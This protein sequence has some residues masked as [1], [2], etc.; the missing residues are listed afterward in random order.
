MLANLTRLLSTVVVATAL[1][2]PT[3]APTAAQ[4]KYASFVMNPTTGE[5]LHEINADTKNYPASLTKMMTLY[6]VFQALEEGRLGMDTA[7]PVSRKAT[8]QPPSKLGLKKG[9]T[10]TV[11]KAINALA[12]KSANDVAVVVAEYLNGTE[13]NFALK[14]TATARTLGM[15]NTTFRNASG[16]PHR[17]QLSTARDMSRLAIA[18]QRDYP[19]YYGVFSRASFKHAGKTYKSHNKLLTTYEGTDGIKT[20]YIR[21]SGFNLV[22]SVK[23]GDTRLIGVV[24]GGKTSNI[25]NAHMTK[26]L[27]K[28]FRKIDVALVTEPARAAKKKT[29][30]G[31]QVGVLGKYDAAFNLASKAVALAPTY[32]GKGDVTV[33]TLKKR[34]SSKKLYRAR[35][36]DVGKRNAYRAC[37]YLKKKRQ[38]CMVFK[39]KA[40]V[41]VASN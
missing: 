14:M 15:K 1:L 40:P 35:I 6:V 16:L 41:T 27:N 33:T 7:M 8:Y 28:S 4:A 36:F 25:R 9:Q 38:D 17:G 30:W 21:A 19:Q 2:V 22:T 23:R 18:L 3:L 37:K 26:L 29:T 10:I 31:I 32:L 12:V 20:G 39:V 13:R 24:L 34:G 5:V 11:R